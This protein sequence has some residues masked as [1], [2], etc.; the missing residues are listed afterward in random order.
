MP[1]AT[2][3]L[4]VF[5]SIDPA[6]EA[7]TRLREMGIQED[8]MQ[9][10]SG[11]PYTSEMLGRHKVFSIIPVFSIIGFLG[12]F[13]I[14][15]VL[16]LGTVWLYPLHVGGLPLYPIPTTIV[17]TFEMAMLG[18]LLFTFLG[19]IWESAFPAYGKK[20]YSKQIS[21]G[22]IGLEFNVPADLHDRVHESLSE[23]GAEWVHRT[24]AVDL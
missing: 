10:I 11:L 14:S 7:I 16:N 5:N 20:I 21:D 19:V 18:L 15:L 23:L 1:E 8:E 9:I 2:V 4:A 12:G 13:V 22:Y 6:S 3:H 17:L 24:E